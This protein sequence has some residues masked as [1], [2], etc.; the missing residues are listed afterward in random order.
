MSQRDAR[1][2]ILKDGATG[3]RQKI[4]ASDGIF[5]DRTSGFREI[6]CA[7]MGSDSSK[8]YTLL[9]K[10]GVLWPVKTPLGKF[11]AQIVAGVSD[12]KAST[13]S[14]TNANIARWINGLGFLLGYAYFAFGKPDSKPSELFFLV[15][16]IHIFKRCFEYEKLQPVFNKSSLAVKLKTCHRSAQGS[17]HRFGSKVNYLTRRAAP[18][19][20][21]ANE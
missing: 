21:A 12:K 16:A 17:L 1:P 18:H 15:D 3:V 14:I 7:W 6:F 11:I 5:P 19:D 20:D 2:G 9:P 4:T 8:D 13:V 10:E